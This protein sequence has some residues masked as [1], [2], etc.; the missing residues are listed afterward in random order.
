MPADPLQAL[1]RVLED[2]VRVHQ[3][4]DVPY[5]LFLSGGLDSSALLALMA[6]LNERP[7]LAFTAGF[8]EAGADETAAARDAARAVGAEA[9]VVPVT[10][11]D[12]FAHLPAILACLDDP[13]ADYAVVPT[14]LLAREARRS[15]KVVLA[16]EGGDELLAGYG[17]YRQYCRPWPLRRPLRR[18][19]LL[20]GLG[21]LRAEPPAWRQALAAAE[22]AA[23]REG[24]TRLMQAQ[25][26]DCADWLP[27][28]LLTKLDRCLMAHG[29][30]GRVPFLDPEVARFCLPLADDL[31]IRGGRGKW[32]LRA[33]L[34]RTLPAVHAFAPKRGFTVP[35]GHWLA[36]HG[37]RLGPLVAATPGVAALC[38]PDRVR[39]LFE[40]LG[41]ETALAA[42]VLLAYAVWHRHFIEEKPG[43]AE[44]DLF[45]CL[46]P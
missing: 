19:S 14:W 7:V 32:L 6:R 33:W 38:H 18:A 30:E 28:D 46:A 22:Q 10:S 20:A 37:A 36:E 11:Q 24:G 13:V 34:E 41:K 12:F 21:L 15:V 23:R 4:S 42:W 25:R 8:P 9:V 3:R 31:K 35:V 43:A 17:R 44:G 40:T 2:S 45:H 27:H 26:I 16:G 1:D 29:L 39:R 5:G